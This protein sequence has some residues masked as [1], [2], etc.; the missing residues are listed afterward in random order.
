MFSDSCF[1]PAN[2]LTHSFSSYLKESKLKC[3]SGWNGSCMKNIIYVLLLQLL[4]ALSNIFNYVSLIISRVVTFFFF[5]CL[6]ACS[7]RGVLFCFYK[8]TLVLDLN[9]LEFLQTICH[10]FCRKLFV[11]ASWV[12]MYYLTVIVLPLPPYLNQ[13]NYFLSCRELLVW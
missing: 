7:M 8:I 4:S 9:V 3:W 11:V 5:I 6:L 12:D 13:E 1:L 10:I 2:D